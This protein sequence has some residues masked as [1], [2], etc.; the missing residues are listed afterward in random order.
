MEALILGSFTMVWPLVFKKTNGRLDESNVWV[1]A[2]SAKKG[3]REIK[4]K[5]FL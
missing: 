3:E 4:N 5:N 1:K 2:W